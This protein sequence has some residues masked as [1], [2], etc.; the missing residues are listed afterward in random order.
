[1][2]L[3][4]SN[5]NLLQICTTQVYIIQITLKVL[6]VQVF[7]SAFRKGNP[8]HFNTCMRKQI[9]FCNATTGSGGSRG[10]APLIFRPNWGP[11]GRKSIFLRPGP[12]YIRVWM[13]GPLPLPEGLDPPLTG[14][15]SKM[16]PKERAQKFCDDLSL[17]RS[18]RSF[19]QWFLS[20]TSGGVTKCHLYSLAILDTCSVVNPLNPNSDWH[21]ISPNNTLP[22]QIDRSWELRK[23]SP[24]MKCC[25]VRTNSFHEYHKEC[26][27]NSVEK[28]HVDAGA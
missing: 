21:P 13:T 8:W 14:S 19:L 7:G 23:W 28:M 5:N 1:M 17:T 10:G 15:S 11:K 9:T 26:M 18:G 2:T 16:T 20:E 27:K 3:N 12:P 6:K 22:D 4:L 25:D 24:K